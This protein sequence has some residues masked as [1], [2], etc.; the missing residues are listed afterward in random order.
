MSA[1]EKAPYEQLS[2]QDQLRYKREQTNY[3]SL[4]DQADNQDDVLHDVSDK[5]K[6]TQKQQK[7]TIS[8][9]AENPKEEV[10]SKLLSELDDLREDLQVAYT[11]IEMLRA[12]KVEEIQTL[13][14]NKEQQSEKLR[15]QTRKINKLTEK[16]NQLE[17]IQDKQSRPSRNK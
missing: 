5:V 12:E 13:Q 11:F 10:E 4:V 1:E 7:H 3:S 2:V 16:V 14:L 17:R 9:Q 8:T 6:Q 15:Q